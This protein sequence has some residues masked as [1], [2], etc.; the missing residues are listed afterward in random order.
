MFRITR[1]RE[2]AKAEQTR[3]RHQLKAF[4]L[5]NGI[6]YAGKTAWTPAHVR[7]LASIKLPEPVQQIVFQD[8]VSA[9]TAAGERL[10]RLEAMLRE[11]IVSWR[12]YPVVQALQTLR[13]VQLVIAA[14]L[15][16][17]IGDIGRFDQPRQLMAYLGL[18]PSE[19]TSGPSTHRGGITKCGNSHARRMLT[20]A[21]WSYRLPARLTP[22]IAKRQEGQSQDVRGIAWKAQVR[23]CS[24]YRQ[25]RAR[26]KEANKVVIA[27]ARELA[28]FVWAIARATRD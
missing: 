14:T 11:T 15:V 8:Y 4:L 6:A 13:G 26:G 12:L 2:D 10:T 17:E 28:G 19:H 20:E 18:V 9:V 1:A 5:R 27:V 25:L 3:A 24:R 22:I 23:L 21:A 7:W 16:A